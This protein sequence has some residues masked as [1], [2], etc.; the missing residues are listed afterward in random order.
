MTS[1]VI[2]AV[3]YLFG[4]A[5]L[6]NAVPHFVSGLMGHP[7]PS[8]FAK[9]PG[10]GLSSPTVNALW[11]LLNFALAYILLCRVGSFHLRFTPHVLAAGLGILSI[12]LMLARH[13]GALHRDNSPTGPGA[14]Q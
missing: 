2:H 10:R 8:P 1:E 13:F 11:G 14:L 6:A 7:F 5:F 9:P 4:G 3:A 12:S